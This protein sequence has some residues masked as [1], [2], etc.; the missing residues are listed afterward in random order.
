MATNEV[1][2]LGRWLVKPGNDD[3]FVEAWKGL[4]TFFQLLP[5]PPGVGTLV[6]SVDN[7]R[8]FYS[9]GPWPSAQAV[10]AMRANPRTPAELAKVITLCEQAEPGTFSHVATVGG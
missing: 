9:F 6:R 7:P 10:A 1:Y 5:E 3:L 4:G 2:T 8:L